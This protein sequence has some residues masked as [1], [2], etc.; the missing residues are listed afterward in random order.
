VSNVIDLL[1][2]FNRKERYFLLKD[3]LGAFNLSAEYR[4]HIG[5]KLALNI[6]ESALVAM[7]YHLTWLYA[8]LVLAAE[9]TTPQSAVNRVIENNAGIVHGNQ[10]DIDLLVAFDDGDMTHIIVI[11]AK[12]V[13]GW[14]NSQLKSKAMRLME[15]FGEAG[16]D[17]ANVVPHFVL[18]S[19]KE[20]KGID[21][22]SWPKWMSQEGK[23]AWIQLPIPSDLL[24]V[25]RTNERAR[26]DKDG[27]YWA[28]LR[29]RAGALAE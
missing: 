25:S 16:T 29:E 6:P 18:T 28:V 11:E 15:I 26:P 5:E 17:R 8:S 13:T 3:A 19:P 23:V 20:S 10:E 12:G 24:R 27:S 22:T 1:R 2:V 14:T 7:D 21:L 9:G 4:G